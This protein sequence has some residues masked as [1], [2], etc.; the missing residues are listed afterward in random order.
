M[1]KKHVGTQELLAKSVKMEFN[2]ARLGPW[3]FF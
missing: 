3:D 2:I 1:E